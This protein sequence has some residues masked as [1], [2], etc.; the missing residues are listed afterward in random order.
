MFLGSFRSVLGV[1]GLLFC[2]Q[3]LELLLCWGVAVSVLVGSVI[4]LVLVVLVLAGLVRDF[5]NFA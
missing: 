1:V 2:L 5:R 4:L 3:C